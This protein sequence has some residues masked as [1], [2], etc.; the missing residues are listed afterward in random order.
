MVASVADLGVRQA[1]NRAGIPED[2]HVPSCVVVGTAG[3]G[4]TLVLDALRSR[5]DGTV[6]AVSGVRRSPDLVFGHLTAG[7]LADLTGVAPSAS[8]LRWALAE[9]LRERHVAALFVDDAHLLDGEAAAVVHSLAVH[10]DVA[11]F[12]ACAA[13]TT[14]V[15]PP[16][17]RSLWKDGY[18]ERYELQPIAEAQVREYLQQQVGHPVT[19]RDVEAFTRWVRGAPGM[20]VALTAESIRAGQWKVI[21]GVAVLTDRPLPP[22]E[23]LEEVSALLAGM[24][25]GVVAVVE[26]FSATVSKVGGRLNDRLPLAAL[27]EFAGMDTLLEAERSGVIEVDDDAVRLA[28][29][30]LADVAAAQTPA[31][32]RAQVARG[33]AT[34]VASSMASSD[35]DLLSATTGLL[36]LSGLAALDCGAALEGRRAAAR[37]A[38]RL[39]D[40]AAVRDLV[41][42]GEASDDGPDDPELAV[43][44]TWAMIDLYDLAGMERMFARWGRHPMPAWRGLVDFMAA[45]RLRRDIGATDFLETFGASQGGLESTVE[46]WMARDRLSGV[47]LGFLLAETAMLIGRYREARAVLDRVR[48]AAGDNGLLDFHLLMVE[49]RLETTV[50]GA[51]VA[52]AKAE[53]ARRASAWRS[54]Y[55][56]AA[57]DFTCALTHVTVGR[58]AAALSELRDSAPFVAGPALDDAPVRLIARIACMSGQQTPVGEVGDP[59][60]TADPYSALISSEKMLD[61]A[62]MLVVGGAVDTAVQRLLDFAEQ[63]IDVAPTLAVDQLELAARFLS[64]GCG[65]TVDRLSVAV[66][67]T[68]ERVEPAA[69]I[70]ALVEYCSALR[71][72]DGAMLDRIGDQYRGLGILP[73]AADAMAQAAEVHRSSGVLGQALSS[74]AGAQRL[75]SVMGALTSPAQTGAAAPVLTRRETQITELVAG[76]LSNQ[77]IAARLSLSVRTVEG[78]ILRASAKFGV[79]DRKSLAAAW[80]EQAT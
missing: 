72:T 58:F 47:W 23:L 9:Q 20:L 12:L 13:G 60:I 5:M 22:A 7:S 39:G 14:H 77:E 75:V 38:L 63:L 17:V 19:E 55:V 24:P 78:H 48:P 62:W 1:L 65:P 25:A 36:T 35:R 37:S 21:N 29:P 68:A 40:P 10:D 6:V 11:V 73:T 74:A 8:A 71:S 61:Q 59:L 70:S 27:V 3:S 64:P 43:L 4:K 2:G 69:R 80:R 31:L 45:F 66:S 28:V 30:F 16:A 52:C 42:G 54:D 51:N 41:M 18:L 79:Q 44:L 67:R 33:L 26:A 53:E 57:A 76:S 49:V 56:C 32:R 34:A 46:T 50:S 15:A